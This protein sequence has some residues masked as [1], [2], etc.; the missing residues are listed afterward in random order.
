MHSMDT[1]EIALCKGWVHVSKDSIVGNTRRK[2]GFCF[3]DLAYVVHKMKVY[4]EAG[5]EEEEEVQEVQRP[6][7]W[8]KAKK[9]AATS[10][11]S[12]TSGNEEVLA[13][14]MIS[15]YAILNEPYLTT[16][17]KDCA[18]FLEIRKKELE[19]KQQKL[20]MRKYEQRQK[21]EMFYMHPTNQLTGVHLERMMEMHADEKE[22]EEV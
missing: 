11:A 12:S 17:I 9:K 6:I 8:D 14:L 7:D 15:E 10:S 1:E 21:D 19:L 16:K 13:R 5:G 4:V 2:V 3:E 20:A 18:A 22:E